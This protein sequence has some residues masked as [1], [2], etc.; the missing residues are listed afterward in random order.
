MFSDY[1]M[2]K[3]EERLLRQ[4]KGRSNAEPDAKQRVPDD[5]GLNWLVRMS[6]LTGKRA[7]KNIKS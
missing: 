4:A 6:E 2:V 3:L 5:V 7:A 1:N